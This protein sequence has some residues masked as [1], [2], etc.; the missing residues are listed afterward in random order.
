MYVKGIY[1]YTQISIVSLHDV[2]K[3]V[4]TYLF[5]VRK[6]HEIRIPGKVNFG[7]C[8]CFSDELRIST[9]ARR[10]PVRKN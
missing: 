7:G 4:E 8:G 1:M 3:N 6:W 10:I 9:L 2:L 5:P